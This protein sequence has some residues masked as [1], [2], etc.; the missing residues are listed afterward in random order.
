MKIV[1]ATKN[2][3]KISEIL[4]KFHD[5]NITGIELLSLNEFPEMPEII[6]DGSTFAENSLIKAKAVSE[7]TGHISM[8][9]DS[10][11]SVDALNGRPGVH[12]ARYGGPGLDDRA[13]NS[14]LLDE[15]K[16]IPVEKRSA[17]FVCAMTLYFPG[18]RTFSVTGEC[19]GK[20]NFAPSG[21]N[22]FGYDPVFFLP[23]YNKTMAEISIEEKNKISHRGKAIESIAEILKDLK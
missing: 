12:S 21:T 7:F 22:G 18:S 3:G 15:M 17:R 8:A 11:L 5:L 4:K 14:L 20:I 2:K 16:D 10:G 19:H 6:E 13:R 9:D 1:T 23:D